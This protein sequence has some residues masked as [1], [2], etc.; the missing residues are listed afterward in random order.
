M[1]AQMRKANVAK[2]SLL[3]F[4][5]EPSIW[6]LRHGCKKI[7]QGVPRPRSLSLPKGRVGLYSLRSR[8][9]SAALRVTIPNANARK[10]AFFAGQEV[11]FVLVRKFRVAG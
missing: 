5:T 10:S 1:L 8:R 9:H 11:I 6:R 7:L 3:I 4:M 2:I